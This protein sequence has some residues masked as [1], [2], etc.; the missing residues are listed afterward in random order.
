MR[1]LF[2]FL[3]PWESHVLFAQL[4]LLS[5]YL[6]GLSSQDIKL[7]FNVLS[8]L[9]YAVRLLLLAIHS[10]CWYIPIS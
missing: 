8:A 6:Q 9:L 5:V 2:C 3:L 7:Y 1:N 4:N 10:G